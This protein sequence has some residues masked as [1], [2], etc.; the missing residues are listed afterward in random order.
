MRVDYRVVFPEA[1]HP[2]RELDQHARA[3]LERPLVELVGLR[4]SQLAGCRHCVQQYAQNAGA[5][6]TDDARL[7]QLSGWREGKLFTQRERAALGW[8]EVL[9]ML[10]VIGSSEEAY[11]ALTTQFDEREI[12]ALTGAVIAANGWNRLHIGLGTPSG[13]IEHGTETTQAPASDPGTRQL[14]NRLKELEAEL[15]TAREE[16][17]RM[18]DGPSGPRYYQS[19]AIHP[20]LDDQTIAPPG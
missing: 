18:V 17:R 14:T 2:L 4:V 8:S 16:Y 13:A 15:A 19:G 11:Q 10:P 3:V 20:E 1:V 7:L 9:T 5:L 6:G 12:V